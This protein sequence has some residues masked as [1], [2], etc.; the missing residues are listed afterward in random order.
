[1]Q[2]SQ[3]EIAIADFVAKDYQC[4][5][6]FN[7]HDKAKLKFTKDIGKSAFIVLGENIKA[8]LEKKIDEDR[9][10]PSSNFILVQLGII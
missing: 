7:E 2:M 5:W 10:L 9:L 3:L 6:A 4:S 1:M 8:Y